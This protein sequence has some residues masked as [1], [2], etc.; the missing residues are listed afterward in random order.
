MKSDLVLLIL[1]SAFFISTPLFSQN[2][3]V[4]SNADSGEGSLRAAI[5]AAN[6]QPGPDTIV[7]NIPG[8]SDSEAGSITL[9]TPLPDITD[10]GLVILGIASDSFPEGGLPRPDILILGSSIMEEA[11]LGLTIKADDVHVSTIF[12]DGFD[13]GGIEFDSVEFGSVSG[14]FI[15]KGADDME[16]KRSTG[17]GNGITIRSSKNVMIGPFAHAPNGNLI[18][19]FSQ[20]G[21]S[22]EDS[23]AFNVIVGNYI[24]VHPGFGRQFADGNGAFGI[25]ISEGSR[26]TEVLDNRVG[27]NQSGGIRIIGATENFIINNQLG[28]DIEFID[29]LGNGGP[30]V[31]IM[32]EA[33]KNSIVENHIGYNEDY[34][35]KNIGSSSLQNRF[36]RNFI[37]R[38]EQGGI[39]NAQGSN[40]GIAKPSVDSIL[41]TKI[42]GKAGA[43]HVIEIFFD[44]GSQGRWYV[45]STRAD[46]NGDFTLT[47]PEV[48]GDLNVTATA[49]DSSGNTSE[50]S[51]PVGTTNL[52]LNLI[53]SNTLDTGNGTL[54]AAIDTANSRVGPD[55][56]RFNIP[57]SDPGFDETKG[58]WIIKPDTFY[59][60]ISDGGLFIDGPSQAKFD[61]IDTNPFGPEIVISGENEG[62]FGSCLVIANSGVEIYGLTI[63]NYRGNGIDILQPG[64]VVISGCYVGT[65][66]AGMEEAGN[67]DGIVV[68]FKTNNVHIGPSDYYPVGNVISGN[69]RIGIFIVDSAMHNVV[70]GNQIGVNRDHSD[71]LGN[72]SRGLNIH[73]H[74][75]GIFDNYIGGNSGEGI[76]IFRGKGNLIS[77]N[78]IGTDETRL[79]NLGN[80]TAV[81]L[82]LGASRNQIIQN[83]IAYSNSYGIYTQGD[84]TVENIFSKNDFHF[85][86]SGDI[87][88]V[89]GG[90]L[91]LT[92]PTISSV[93]NS[94]VAGQASANQ[95]V[96]IYVD[97]ED[98]G[99]IYLDS[100]ITDSNGNF[101]LNLQDPVPA[102]L[103]VLATAR[104]TAGNTSE[105]SDPRL[106]TRISESEF[107]G[108]VLLFQNIPNPAD[109][110]TIIKYQVN[111]ACHITLALMDDRGRLT[112]ELLRAHVF[113][114]S[115]SYELDVSNLVPGTYYYSLLLDGQR[116]AAH[117]MIV[118]PV[119]K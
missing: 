12:I 106:V 108:H 93:S 21:I 83:Q 105:F 82:W 47:L 4:T 25:S 118:L 9:L 23:S 59:S 88:N 38:N 14:C 2:T 116:V 99:V 54:R 45:D 24:G 110:K 52:Q 96:E 74:S 22:I 55:T 112:N 51:D 70:V 28:T 71:V 80:G 76:G 1:I 50:F 16:E 100:A 65:D 56:I 77:S 34:G 84:T 42:T 3:I 73:G 78:Y 111:K 109:R 115:Y 85:N 5:E 60:F 27:Q 107:G 53:V 64:E 81:Y 17:E 86:N 33:S 11:P 89:E 63:Q 58:V 87:E 13:G 32:Q 69:D 43:N 113:P 119:P 41:G 49:R 91:E 37:S 44:E 61:S 36:S 114:G 35:I 39:L 19:G 29:T 97:Q 62:S 8:Q 26:F 46:S 90:N 75:N 40:Q 68:G 101:I 117:K 98:D 15:G 95:I 6:T 79:S 66:Y 7:F 57:R 67:N 102:Q 48:P 10:A 20:H 18:S 31:L 72:G 94:A 103:S 104:D 92:P 30:G